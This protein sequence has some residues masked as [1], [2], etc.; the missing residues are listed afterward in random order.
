[1]TR[2]TVY[3]NVFQ[4]LARPVTRH[5]LEFHKISRDDYV[6]LNLKRLFWKRVKSAPDFRA[7]FYWQTSGAAIGDVSTSWARFSQSSN[8]DTQLL[9]GGLG[10]GE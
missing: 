5:R 1:M 2:G 8:N 10:R 4:N 9:D 3:Q 6:S 7:L